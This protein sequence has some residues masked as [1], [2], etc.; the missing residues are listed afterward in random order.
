MNIQELEKLYA[1][2]PQVSALAKEIGKTQGR[3]CGSNG[4]PRG[5]VGFLRTDGLWKHVCKV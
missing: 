5:I 2:L 3:R 4:F 1:Q